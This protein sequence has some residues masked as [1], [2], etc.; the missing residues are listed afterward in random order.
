VV[1]KRVYIG[2]GL[3][4]WPVWTQPREQPDTATTGRGRYFVLSV[5]VASANPGASTVLALYGQVNFSIPLFKNRV[6]DSLNTSAALPIRS[7]RGT[8]CAGNLP[9]E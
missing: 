8:A 3:R 1:K 5:A 4:G 7:Q 2:S 9:K 6:S